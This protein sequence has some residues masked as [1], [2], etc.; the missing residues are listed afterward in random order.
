MSV[1]LVFVGIIGFQS[2]ESFAALGPLSEETPIVSEIIAEETET[3]TPIPT[4]MSIGDYLT[5]SITDGYYSDGV[6][7]VPES[8]AAYLTNSALPGEQGNIIIYGHNKSHILGPLSQTKV[9][10]I[11]TITNSE[12]GVR[13]YLA[14]LVKHITTEELQY[15]QPTDAETLTI[16][17]CAGWLDRDRFL[18]RA[19]PV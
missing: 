12:G 11:I 9:G 8:E 17:T 18:V 14:E 13:Q 4:Q 1:L 16:Y 2:P 15:L 7:T 10:D 19:L 6:W 3:P 5:V